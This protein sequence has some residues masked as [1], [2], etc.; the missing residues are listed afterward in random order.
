MV[1]NLLEDSNLEDVGVN[2]RR[3]VI[4]MAVRMGDGWNWLA[5]EPSG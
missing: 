2:I 4:E 1:E 3:C 5:I